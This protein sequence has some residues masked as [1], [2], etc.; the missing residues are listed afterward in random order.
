MRGGV[1]VLM[2]V[3]FTEILFGFLVEGLLAAERTEVI[4]LTVV[5]GCACGGGGI[6]VHVADGVMYGSC[7]TLSPFGDQDLHRIR[8]RC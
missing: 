3:F 6:N 5:F 1:L 8:P 2:L 4:G 7:H